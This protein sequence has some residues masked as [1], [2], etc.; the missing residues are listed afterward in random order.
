MAKVARKK[1]KVDPL[2]FIRR[3]INLLKSRVDFLDGEVRNAGDT[4]APV[5]P[6][7]DADGLR[8][9]IDVLHDRLDH[10]DAEF[11]LLLNRVSKLE[12]RTA[13]LE[14]EANSVEETNI[15]G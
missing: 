9:R 1:K 13:G 12:Q 8:A 11:R 3:Q 10:N 4:Y 14:P 15:K 6:I 5:K 7:M 2:N